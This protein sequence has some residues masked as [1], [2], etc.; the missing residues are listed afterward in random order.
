MTGD[1]VL[2]AADTAVARERARRERLAERRKALG[3]TQERLAELLEVARTTVA[4]WERGEAQPRPWLRPRLAKALQV[5]ADRI[6]ELLTG[7][8][9]QAG[10]DQAGT[11]APGTVAIGAVGGTAGVG[12]TELAVELARLVT[13]I[14]EF[15]DAL[16]VT[17]ERIPPQP[18]SSP[19]RDAGPSTLR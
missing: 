5:G 10:P 4:R 15:L 16:G 14:H 11:G 6:E 8:G 2:V 12:E 7:G 19:E 1:G 3:L 13:A 17:P 18:A 9:C